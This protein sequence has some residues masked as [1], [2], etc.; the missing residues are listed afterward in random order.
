[1]SNLYVCLTQ[2]DTEI[3]NKWRTGVFL[4]LQNERKFRLR[5]KNM[6]NA[7]VKISGHSQHVNVSVSDVSSILDLPYPTV[8]NV[9][10]CVLPFYPQK[11]ACV[12]VARRGLRGF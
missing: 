7:D 9:L 3:S 10:N 11:P 4:L 1:M 5:I 12:L 8:Q 2:D 6:A